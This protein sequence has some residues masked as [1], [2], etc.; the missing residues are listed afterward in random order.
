M[1]LYP[2]GQAP[3]GVALPYVVWQIATGSP[4][5]YLSDTPD[6]D[7]FTTQVDVYSATETSARNTAKAIRDA[8]EP[9]AHVVAWRGESTDQETQH[10]RY[11]FDVEWHVKR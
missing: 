4:E 5:N 11:S 3:Q 6:V 1:R 7:R 9:V 10:K 2:F 8:V